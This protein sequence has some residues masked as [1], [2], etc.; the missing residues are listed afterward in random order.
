M[1]IVSFHLTTESCTTT[2]LMT[3]R[4]LCAMCPNLKNNN[5]EYLPVDRWEVRSSSAPEWTRRAWMEPCCVMNGFYV[6]SMLDGCLY[7]SI[8]AY[9]ALK[10]NIESRWCNEGYTSLCHCA[11]QVVTWP[12]TSYGGAGEKSH[13]PRAPINRFGKKNSFHC[14]IEIEKPTHWFRFWTSVILSVW[15]QQSLL[16]SIFTAH[17]SSENIRSCCYSRGSRYA[18][19]I[20]FLFFRYQPF[21]FHRKPNGPPMNKMKKIKR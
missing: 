14:K 13:A 7:F 19:E 8:S 10:M 20:H 15:R 4:N 18:T 17:F 5:N 1:K 3:T 9:A 21:V 12:F 6:C 16:L 2:S 11:T